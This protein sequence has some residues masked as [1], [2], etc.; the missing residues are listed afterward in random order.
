MHREDHQKKILKIQEILEERQKIEDDII[1][2]KFKPNP[3]R[4]EMF[5]SQFENILQEEKFKR[6]QRTEKIKARIIHEMKPFSFFEADEKRFKEKANK[7]CEVP[8]FMPFKSTPIPWT[9]QVNL[10]EDLIEKS[11][12]K[13]RLRLEER[14]METLNNA[15]LPPRME[16]HE[17]IKREKIQDMKYLEESNN[18]FNKRSQSFR[19]I[20][21]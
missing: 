1:N 17:K 14:A 6:K 5:F 8:S 2:Y 11:S 9:S 3:P 12:E 18:N 16:M 7:I 13:R 21:Y 4:R 19:V 15:R 10:Y 20:K